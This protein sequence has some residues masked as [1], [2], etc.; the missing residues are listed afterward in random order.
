[1]LGL[2]P[3][4]RDSFALGLCFFGAQDTK[5]RQRWQQ[6]WQQRFL[7]GEKLVPIQGH[8]PQR[9][10]IIVQG[11][12]S[13]ECVVHVREQVAQL[14]AIHQRQNLAD[15]VGAGFALADDLVPSSGNSQFALQ[16]VQAAQA[17]NKHHQGAQEDRS[18]WNLR[19]L[20][21]IAQ[22]RDLSAPIEDFLN[23][24]AE[25]LIHK[26]LHSVTVRKLRN[27]CAGIAARESTR[28]DDGGQDVRNGK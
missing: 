7:L 5:L 21:R 8:K 26:G 22:G 18:V 4:A 23:V 11:L 27:C 20:A 1:M 3:F 17:C 2:D 12:V 13:P 16:A 9:P 6:S 24:T 25:T 15:A 19:L 14:A 10:G 28:Q